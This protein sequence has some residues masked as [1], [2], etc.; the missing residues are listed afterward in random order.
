MATRDAIG[1]IGAIALDYRGLGIVW[2]N[3]MVSCG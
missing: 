3:P 1:A 2:E